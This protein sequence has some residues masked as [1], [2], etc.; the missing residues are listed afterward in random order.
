MFDKIKSLIFGGGNTCKTEIY[1]HDN[2]KIRYEGSIKGSNFH[3][4]GKYY[5]EEGKLCYEGLFSNGFPEGEGKA[6]LEDGSTYEGMFRKGERTGTGVQR[7]SDGSYYEGLF[8]NGVFEGRGKL[9]STDG[10]LFEGN[11]LKGHLQGTGT[12]NYP[13][14]DHYE[15]EFKDGIETGMGKLFVTDG[16]YEGE[17][18][19]GLPNGKGCLVGIGFGAY[20]SSEKSV[21]NKS[22]EQELDNVALNDTVF[23]IE[24]GG[25]AIAISFKTNKAWTASADQSWCILSKTSGEAGEISITAT[26]DANT[27]D[28]ERIAQ[29]TIKAGT[30]TATAIVKQAKKKEEVK[31]KE[32][33]PKKKKE[34]PEDKEK[35]NKKKDDPTTRNIG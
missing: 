6:Y 2:G 18:L 15:G 5:N 30:A 4:L 11:F 24:E 14:G 21:D 31:K 35:E 8:V 12:A 7:F 26:V 9:H 33:K 10:T 1:Y 13:N 20:H 27:T 16:V 17:V 28:Q 32:K 23:T 3:G 25:K 22:L 29:I 19:A 34:E